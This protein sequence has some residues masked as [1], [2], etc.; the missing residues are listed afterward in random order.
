VLQEKE[1]M[2]K[3]TLHKPL[4]LLCTLVIL[5]ACSGGKKGD[6]KKYDLSF[7]SLKG[8]SF[9][10]T[11]NSDMD[12]QTQLMGFKVKMKMKMNSNIRFDLLPDSADMK[13][14]KMTYEDLTMS[15][16]FDN[17]MLQKAVSNQDLNSQVNKMTN[18]FKGKS[19]FL[20]V[21]R[22]GEIK[23]VINKDQFREQLNHY[24]DSIMDNAAGGAG[25]GEVDNN[26][27]QLYSKGDLQNMVGTIFA[28]YNSKPVTTGDEWEKEYGITVNGID[29]KIK[30]QFKL[31]AVKDGIA[32]IEMTGKMSASGTTQQGPMKVET[33][34]DGKQT[35][36]IRV[37]LNNGHV[38]LSDTKMDMDGNVKM[39]GMKMPMKAKTAYTI[40]SN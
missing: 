10:N 37:Q 27:K 23:E 19:L 3:N 2:K 22:E 18:G 32:E 31:L 5:A 36:L 15:M 28:V 9:T 33:D 21:S 12:V 39:M 8:P 40:K 30:N 11:I 38:L 1:S 7:N 17:P 25:K 29:T 14:L 34:T 16:E 20:L 26:L 35:G 4:Y 6:G 13:Q 24:S